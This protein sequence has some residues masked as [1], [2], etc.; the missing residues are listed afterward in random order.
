[1]TISTGVAA[2]ADGAYGRAEEA[3]DYSRKIAETLHG[4]M[5][6]AISEMSPDY[7]C[8][9]QAW[10]GYGIAWPLVTQI[11]GV[12]P[13][14][15]QKRLLLK[16]AFPAGWPSARLTGVRI[17]SGRFDFTW[18]GARLHVTAAEPGWTIIGG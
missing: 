6:G 4:H 7:G 10:S 2:V 11:F 12:Q 1:M 8:F 17:G 9:V 16:P 15:H 13:D 14:A 3:L 5:P 18:D